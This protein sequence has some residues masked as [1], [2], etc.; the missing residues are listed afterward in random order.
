MNSARY[1]ID[2]P[3]LTDLQLAWACCCSTRTVERHRAR[4]GIRRRR[5]RPCRR[6]TAYRWVFQGERPT[7]RKV[8]C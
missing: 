8:L 4:L 1:I 3:D 7:L 5:G 2:H 6:A